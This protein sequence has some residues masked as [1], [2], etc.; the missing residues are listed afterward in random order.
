MAKHDEEKTIFQELKKRINELE[1]ETSKLTQKEKN[2]EACREK[3]KSFYECAPLPYQALD[4]NGCLL[5]V[6]PRWLEELG[7]SHEEVIGQWFGDFLVPEDVDRFQQFFPRFK[8]AI[9][10]C[11]VEFEMVL[12]DGPVLIASFTILFQDHLR[13]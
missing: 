4:E 5:D 7:Y 2:L 12:K 11:G 13:R 6:N 10:V 8:D 9:Q 3:L 1:A